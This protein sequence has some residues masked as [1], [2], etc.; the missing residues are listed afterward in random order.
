MAGR[1]LA[2][3]VVMSIAVLGSSRTA[4]GQIVPVDDPCFQKSMEHGLDSSIGLVQWS[5]TAQMGDALRVL[6]VF[7]EESDEFVQGAKAQ[8]N[9]G[10]SLSTRQLKRLNDLN[11]CLPW[12]LRL[13]STLDDELKKRGV[14]LIDPMS[15]DQKRERAAAE[16]RVA[17]AEAGLK[18]VLKVK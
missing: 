3:A 11:D 12:L 10:K 8:F 7:A 2:T 14:N 5:N 17:N 9:A 6:R 1:Q 4:E 16:Q 15:D 18:V 13:M